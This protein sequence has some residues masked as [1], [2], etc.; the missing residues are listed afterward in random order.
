MNDVNNNN[1]TTTIP[2]PSSSSPNCAWVDETC[3]KYIST[4]NTFL[5][6]GS[7]SI[8]D[9]SVRSSNCSSVLQCI[10]AYQQCSLLYES[11]CPSSLRMLN[12]YRKTQE[13]DPNGF[14]TYG[15]GYIN[16]CATTS[17]YDAIT[18][19]CM[20]S[21]FSRSS[22]DVC[23]DTR[24]LGTIMKCNYAYG[25]DQNE[26]ILL[27]T[28]S[29]SRSSCD[30]AANSSVYYPTDGPSSPL[31][32]PSYDHSSALSSFVVVLLMVIIVLAV[33]TGIYNSCL[34]RRA[35]REVQAEIR[36]DLE[37]ALLPRRT[38]SP[39]QSHSTLMRPI[40]GMNS[41]GG[42]G[43]GNGSGRNSRSRDMLS[44]F[45]LELGPCYYSPVLSEDL[46]DRLDDAAIVGRVVYSPEREPVVV[47][48]VTQ[49]MV[50]RLQ[51]MSGYTNSTSPEEGGEEDGDGSE[52]T[53]EGS[54][55]PPPAQPPSAP[56]QPRSLQDDEAAIA[57]A[58][59]ARTRRR[60]LLDE[61]EERFPSPNVTLNRTPS[62][63]PVRDDDDTTRSTEV[64]ALTRDVPQNRRIIDFE[65]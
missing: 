41:E 13:L 38:F 30:L 48:E 46:R 65:F 63:D 7:S 35:R 25:C 15:K 55:S 45:A 24:C 18:K 56:T 36:R 1:D 43:G 40:H 59:A 31:A 9:C 34:V 10:R 23:A 39:P 61:L 8:I 2:S 20:C 16:P 62:P 27:C 11:Y 33:V 44:G 12:C 49:E 3:R 57:S 29:C 50:M 26:S 54:S 37:E 60:T 64:E 58:A 5:L 53:T 4:S 32:P 21:S 22:S 42:G 6:N 51:N 28:S 19:K 47:P 52:E 14:C 17:C